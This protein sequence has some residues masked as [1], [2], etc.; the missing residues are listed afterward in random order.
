MNAAEISAGDTAWVLASAALVLLM[1]LGLSFFYGGMVRAKSVL[2]MVM[3]SV[4]T[5]GIV[6]VLWVLF[7]FSMVFGESFG[8]LVGNPLDFAGLSALMGPDAVVGTVPALAF[9]GFQ[10]AF[11]IIAVALVSG[12][13]ADRMKFSAW[14]AFAAAWAVLVYF[15]AAHW[16]FAGDGVV[17]ENGGFIV[18]ALGAVDF[19]GGTAI[20]INAGAA[21]LVLAVILGPRIGLGSTPMRPHNLPLVMLGA[22]LLWFGWFGFNSGSA[23]AADP[24]A[25]HAW[26]T[27]LAAPAAGMLAWLIVEK[28]RDGRPTSLGAASGIVAGLVGITPAAAAVSPM[29]ALAIGALSGVGSALAIGLKNKLG[30]DDSLDV[31][32]VHLVAGLIGT[33]SIGFLADPAAPAEARGLLYGGG[34]ELLAIEAVSSLAVLIYSLVMT[35]IIALIL[36]GIMGGLRVTA[37]EESSGIDV[38]AHAESGYDYSQ[39]PLT[40][41]GVTRSVVIPAPAPAP[42]QEVN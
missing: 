13:V 33:L 42:A 7:G 3:M 37:R 30:Y 4:V 20:H 40:A 27:T 23:L 16:V 35:T 17:S 10:A 26:V 31:V 2:N 25:A 22:G 18:N 39:T 11:A 5:M 36:R 29:G 14:V 38:A 32:G 15:P 41:R 19:A 9:V 8:G 6:G 34:F 12:A 21:A 24:V 28:I 1:T